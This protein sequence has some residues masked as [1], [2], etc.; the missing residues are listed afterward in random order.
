M[1]SKIFYIGT[2]DAFARKLRAVCNES[3][4][5]ISFELFFNN[6]ELFNKDEYLIILYEKET[7][8]SEMKSI[9]RRK[10]E[11]P[12]YVILL[13]GDSVTLEE[14]TA[15]K[16]FG[17][18]DVL[19]PNLEPEKLESYIKVEQKLLDE[20]V[21][22]QTVKV[23]HLPLWKRI[24][25][26]IVSGTAILILSPLFIL[27]A[28]VIRLESK[29][30]IVYKSKRVGSNYRI[31]DFLKFRSMYPDADRRMK[32]FLALN[33]YQNDPGDTKRQV[34]PS[35][36]FEDEVADEPILIA[37][38]F[39]IKESQYLKELHNKQ[40]N[41]FV[42]FTNDPRI[43]RVG[44]FIRKYSIDELPQLFNVL[45]GDMSI[46]GNRPLPLYEA[47]LLT[48]DD[49]IDRFLAPS[50]ITGLWQVEKRG[51]SGK[52]SAAERKDLDVYYAKNFSL[53][54]DMKIILKT[55]TSFIQKENV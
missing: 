44:R 12:R 1:K 41:S 16:S 47:E 20:T 21:I 8:L 42:K 5:F 53:A 31:F 3:E 4:S 37:D 28:L 17:V 48:K 35:D 51:D 26:I 14:W 27:V 43:T 15:F 55:F 6:V 34:T 36:E 13:I 33:Q 25:D 24:F 29:G 32:E 45:K 18:V 10:D 22:P 38:D 39:E 30:K 23:F 54:M 11:L 40:A 7:F 46:V 50:G 2:N 9:K 49:S 52:M 19:S